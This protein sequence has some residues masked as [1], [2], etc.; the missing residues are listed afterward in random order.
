MVVRAKHKLKGINLCWTSNFFPWVICIFSTLFY[1]N[2]ESDSIILVKIATSVL[3]ILL[4][5]PNNLAL[6]VSQTI[7]HP[8]R[9]KILLCSAFI[10]LKWHLESD[11]LCVIED[12]LKVDSINCLSNLYHTQHHLGRVCNK[13]KREEINSAFGVSESRRGLEAIGTIFCL[14]F[15][16]Q[17]QE[18]FRF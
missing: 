15:V 4:S 8:V 16:P 14:L 7:F 12:G 10:P 13:A 9:L 1:A 5:Y 11:A 6:A 18:I 3:C 2:E 17:F